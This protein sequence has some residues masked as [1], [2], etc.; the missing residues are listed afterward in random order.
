VENW[1]RKNLEPSDSHL[2]ALTFADKYDLDETLDQGVRVTTS[3]GNSQ[4]SYEVIDAEA[5]FNWL[6]HK[7]V[8]D[9]LS[10]DE[11][12]RLLDYAGFLLKLVADEGIQPGGRL[13]FETEAGN[14]FRI[15][16]NDVE[17]MERLLCRTGRSDDKTYVPR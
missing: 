12:G 10:D 1:T 7:H 9:L 4:F 14:T 17:E 8:Q 5:L 2:S 3:D 15:P 16:W 11:I 13:E 6:R